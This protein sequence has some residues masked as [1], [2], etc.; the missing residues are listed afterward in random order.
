MEKRIDIYN[1]NLKEKKYSIK[2]NPDLKLKYISK[3]ANGEVYSINNFAII[4]KKIP[5]SIFKMWVPK[6]TKKAILE[7]ELLGNE[8]KASIKITKFA[9]KKKIPFYPLFYDFEVDKKNEFLYLYY[10]EIENM[11]ELRD[12]LKNTYNQQIW[13]NIIL[14]LL[15]SLYILNKKL[16]ITHNDTNIG[17]VLIKKSSRKGYDVF[18]DIYIPNIGFDV[19]LIDYGHAKFTKSNKG[20]CLL[21]HHKRIRYILK[22]LCNKNKKELQ[23]IIKDNKIK[24]VS[25]DKYFMGKRTVCHFKYSYLINLIG[26][27]LAK[28]NTDLKNTKISIPYHYNKIYKKL[29][30]TSKLCYINMYKWILINFPKYFGKPK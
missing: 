15:V 6:L 9:I 13:E 24:K 25:N 29:E 12:I 26:N 11:T 28:Y 23:K 10:E 21:F 8:I 22:Q 19:Y 18:D 4:V 7:D 20:E 1:K 17:N 2:N 3:G 16:N 27:H 14:R 30:K 5:Y